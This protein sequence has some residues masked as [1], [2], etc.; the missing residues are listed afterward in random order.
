MYREL[1][2]DPYWLATGK[3]PY[4]QAQEATLPYHLPIF[5]VEASSCLDT[6]ENRAESQAES[7]FA[8]SAHRSLCVCRIWG[9]FCPAKPKLQAH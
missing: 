5:E 1:R 7:A 2:K 4:P 6:P 8:A 9:T 3:D